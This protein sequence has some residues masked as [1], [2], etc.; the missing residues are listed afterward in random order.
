MLDEPVSILDESMQIAFWEML[1]ALKPHVAVVIASHSLERMES[2]ADRILLLHKGHLVKL[3]TPQ[4]IAE[5]YQ[6]ET[7]RQ[8]FIAFINLIE[9]TVHTQ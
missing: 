6:V 5:A 9:P 2:F 1:Y 7:L 4:A 3:G 8:A